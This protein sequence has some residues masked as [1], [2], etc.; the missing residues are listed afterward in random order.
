MLVIDY[1]KTLIASNLESPDFVG[2]FTENRLLS[3]IVSEH[4][5]H[6]IYLL[7]LKQ[8]Y[9]RNLVSED[10]LIKSEFEKNSMLLKDINF[11]EDV[12]N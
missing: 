4:I 5:H 6:D 12:T 3:H 10:I 11:G 7:K 9:N 1:D 2:T 8:K